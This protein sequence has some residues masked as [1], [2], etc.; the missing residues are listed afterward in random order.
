MLISTPYAT[1][2]WYPE[3]QRGMSQVGAAVAGNMMQTPAGSSRSNG[4]V[5]PL[6][7]RF[8]RMRCS[9]MKVRAVIVQSADPNMAVTIVSIAP[10]LSLQER[11][12]TQAGAFCWKEPPRNLSYCFG[13]EQG[14]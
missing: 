7:F 1:S 13:A 3:A 4:L 5:R 2:G 14:K 8:L 9:S 12:S 10:G 6:D 11:D